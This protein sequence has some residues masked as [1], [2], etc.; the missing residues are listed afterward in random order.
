MTEAQATALVA[1]LV[2]GFPSAHIPAE[3]VQVYVEELLPL[4]AEAGLE[5]V[6]IATRGARWFPTIA[7]VLEAYWQAVE[8]RVVR[9]PALPEAPLSEEDRAEGLRVAREFLA[10]HGMIGREMP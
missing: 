2:A 10:R 6:K 3:T 8:S 1:R 4:N 9:T 5:A 7:E